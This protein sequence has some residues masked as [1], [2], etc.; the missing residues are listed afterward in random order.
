MVQL[1]KI[2]ISFKVTRPKG[3][4][5][6]LIRR[7][8]ELANVV[9]TLFDS[10][11]FDLTEEMLLLFLNR[12]NE[13]M[14]YGSIAKGGLTGVVC[15]VRVIMTMALLTGST[16]IVIAHNHPSGSIKPSQQDLNITEQV[17]QAGLVHEIKLL[18]HIIV[19]SDSYYSMRD[20][21]H[22]Y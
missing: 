22:I 9:R 8:E 3:Y 15:D 2:T 20:E 16:Y 19:T 10:N 13:L 5:P 1:P 6:T 18:D 11:T 7:S 12:R 17:R 14:H 4:T 21:G